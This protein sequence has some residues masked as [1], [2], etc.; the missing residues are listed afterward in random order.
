MTH[1]IFYSSRQK[2]QSLPNRKPLQFTLIE[3]LVVIAII[4]ILAGMLLPA[5]S[6]AKEKAQGISCLSQLKQNALLLSLYAGDNSDMLLLYTN[7][8]Y[9][10]SYMNWY[11]IL[12]AGG[13]A[14]TT[15]SA[16]A[17]CPIKDPNAASN[18]Y[19]VNLYPPKYV[20]PSGFSM[21]NPGLEWGIAVRLTRMKS[22]SRFMLLSDSCRPSTDGKSQWYQPEYVQTLYK[23]N[24]MLHARHSNAINS[25]FADG[26]AASQLPM[27]AAD[28]LYETYRHTLPTEGG[29]WVK[30]LHY[31]S[32]DRIPRSTPL[33]EQVR[34]F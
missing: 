29:S 23:D 9:S 25:S 15:P 27:Q 1:R 30:A 33:K 20:R 22:P 34:Y 24:P 5:L 4:A 31:Y 11:K 17:A 18:F 32:K 6:K 19:G 28:S 2:T 7:N 26:S 16:A 8:T 21:G 12:A 3:L 10:G 13:Y 14:G